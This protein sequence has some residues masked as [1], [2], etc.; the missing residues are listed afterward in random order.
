MRYW[1]FLLGST[2]WLGYLWWLVDRKCDAV[3]PMTDR[4]NISMILL[5]ALLL[6]MI[7]REIIS[8]ERR[9]RGALALSLDDLKS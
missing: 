4:R 6:G 3:W 7:R 8:D 9:R 1:S 2:Q 5:S